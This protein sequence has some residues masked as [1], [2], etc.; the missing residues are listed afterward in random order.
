[1]YTCHINNNANSD[2]SFGRHLVYVV[3]ETCPSM[4]RS[5]SFRTSHVPEGTSIIPLQDSRNE[6]RI[7]EELWN[8]RQ[9]G[10]H[11]ACR[12]LV[13]LAFISL[14]M[15]IQEAILKPEPVY[16]VRPVPRF[17]GLAEH[18][19]CILLRKGSRKTNNKASFLEHRF[20]LLLPLFLH[21]FFFLFSLAVCYSSFSFMIFVKGGSF[22]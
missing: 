9:R 14:L 13:H 19:C 3:H 16:F 22:W 1:M 7:E 18:I 17:W 8:L 4:C 11:F 21:G 12:F 6:L 10:Y 15:C 20:V 5:T 2:S